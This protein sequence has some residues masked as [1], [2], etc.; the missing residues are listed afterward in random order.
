MIC[1]YCGYGRHAEIRVIHDY[2]GK[3][4]I[5]D[6][7]LACQYREQDNERQHRKFDPAH[8]LHMCSEGFCITCGW[9]PV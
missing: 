1:R 5:C 7:A 3:G 9:E 4:P 2:D 6:D 8:A